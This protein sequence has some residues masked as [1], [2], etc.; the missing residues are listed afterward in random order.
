[1]QGGVKRAKAMLT[2]KVVLKTKSKV[3]WQGVKKAKARLNDRPCQ[4]GAKKE[5]PLSTSLHTTCSSQVDL[6]TLTSVFGLSM[7]HS[8]Q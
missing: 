7:D 5:N 8:H 4:G 6:V 1:M 2:D 3:E